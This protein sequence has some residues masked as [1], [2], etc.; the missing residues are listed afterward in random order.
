MEAIYDNHNFLSVCEF[1]PNHLYFVTVQNI[2]NGGSCEA[3]IPHTDDLHFFNTDNEFVYH[4]FYGDFGPL[5]LYKFCKKLTNK[6]ATY[7]GEAFYEKFTISRFGRKDIAEKLKEKFVKNK[8]IVYYTSTNNEKRANAAFLIG[9]FAI[10]Y[11]GYSPR[12][13]Y[14]ALQPTKLRY[15]PF[16]D[17]SVG[18]SPYKINM[19]NCLDALHKASIFGFFN[20]NDFNV[21]ECCHYENIVH[22]DL[23]WIVPQKFIAFPGPVE[24]K[25]DYYHHPNFYIEYFLCNNVTDVIRLNQRAYDAKCFTMFNMKHHDL[26]MQDGTDPPDSILKSFMHIAETA[27]GAI[28]V[29]CKAGLGRTGSLIG[30]YLLKHYRMTAKEAIAWIRICRPGSVIGHQQTWLENHEDMLWYEGNEWRYKMYGKKEI[31]PFLQY[32][33]YSFE[34]PRKEF[35]GLPELLNNLTKRS[36]YRFI[37]KSRSKKSKTRLHQ[38]IKNLLDNGKSTKPQ[39]NELRSEKPNEVLASEENSSCTIEQCSSEISRSDSKNLHYLKAPPQPEDEYARQS[40]THDFS[41]VEY[42]KPLPPKDYVNPFEPGQTYQKPVEYFNPAFS[43][44][45]TPYEDNKLSAMYCNP[46]FYSHQSTNDYPASIYEKKTMSPQPAVSA[47]SS[48]SHPAPVFTSPTRRRINRTGEMPMI[49]SDLT[50][51]V[52]YDRKADL[53]SKSIDKNWKQNNYPYSKLY[54][55]NGIH[56]YQVPKSS[57]VMAR[58]SEEICAFDSRT[59]T[60]SQYSRF[61]NPCMNRAF[62]EQNQKTGNSMSEDYYKDNKLKGYEGSKMLDRSTHGFLLSPEDLQSWVETFDEKVGEVMG[63]KRFSTKRSPVL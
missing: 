49:C 43:G 33:I 14:K 5:S 28:A 31:V 1:L 25:N 16:Q 6:L 35:P 37:V 32:G 42:R 20:F 47:T 40:C 39:T 50:T 11:L 56:S 58:G 45:S 24:E 7:A 62:I 9:A 22:G 15:R 53:L 23:N 54:S 57:S 19:K 38:I 4:N 2:N 26:Y 41:P 30:A 29:H 36:R 8:V 18:L 34:A 46:G 21:A 44:T 55:T 61:N 59:E 48:G 17:A 63:S 3:I 27:S 13:A 52:K 60:I 51:P 10:L 12:L